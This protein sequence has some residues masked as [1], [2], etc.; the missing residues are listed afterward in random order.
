MKQPLVLLLFIASIHASIIGAPPTNSTQSISWSDWGHTQVSNLATYAQTIENSLSE[1]MHESFQKDLREFEEHK[2][3]YT[4]LFGSVIAAITALIAFNVYLYHAAKPSPKIDP[5][6]FS[7][8]LS[9]QGLTNRI[10]PPINT[11]YIVRIKMPNVPPAPP[12]GK[13]TR[14]N[15]FKNEGYDSAYDIAPYSN[16]D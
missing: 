1:T 15:V 2:T 9:K 14:L 8:V 11:E 4:I 7:G 16:T 5:V 3:Y 13:H 10:P 12:A 6:G